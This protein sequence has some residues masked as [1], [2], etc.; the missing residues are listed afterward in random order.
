MSINI[1]EPSEPLFRKQLAAFLGGVGAGSTAA[2][3]Y[4]VQLLPITTTQKNALGNHEGMVVFD[5]TLGKL[6]VN[7]GASWETITSS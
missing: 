6:C 4:S 5:H 2:G 1:Y 3:I 7:N